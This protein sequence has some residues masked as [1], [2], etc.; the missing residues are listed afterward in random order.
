[1]GER[2]THK[3][4]AP[5]L[6]RRVPWLRE[7]KLW[8]PSANGDRRKVK[9]ETTVEGNPQ[10]LLHRKALGRGKKSSKKG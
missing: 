7:V 9:E 6:G 4:S 1:M 2:R 10:L 5:G 3:N 8:S